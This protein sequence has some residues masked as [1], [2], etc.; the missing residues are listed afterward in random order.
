[1]ADALWATLVAVKLAEIE[2]PTT[3]QLT[4]QWPI[5]MTSSA[6]LLTVSAMADP[7]VSDYKDW[8][9]KASLKQQALPSRTPTSF[10]TP[11]PFSTPTQSQLPN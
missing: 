11:F 8:R 5:T 2:D 1:M 4:T 3:G 6:T 7:N 10:P 9:W